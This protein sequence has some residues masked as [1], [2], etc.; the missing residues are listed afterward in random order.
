MERIKPQPYTNSQEGNTIGG[1]NVVLSSH[2]GGAAVKGDGNTINE[3]SVIL[4]FLDI[5]EQQGKTIERLQEQIGRL[6]EKIYKLKQE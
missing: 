1:D 2:D 4:R 5:I 6:T 3:S